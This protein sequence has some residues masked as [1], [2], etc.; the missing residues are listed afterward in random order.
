MLGDDQLL[1]N[2]KPRPGFGAANFWLAVFGEP[3]AEKPWAIQL[4]GHHIAVNITLVGEQIAMSPTFIGVQPHKFPFK[5]KEIVPMA[6][7]VEDAFAFVGALDDEQKNSAIVAEK[8]ADVQTAAGKDGFIPEAKGLKCDSLTEAQTNALLKLI[9]HWVNDL[10]AKQA[11]ARMKEIAG[12]IK[13]CHF[14]WSGPTAPGSDISFILQGPS[15]ILEYACQDLGGKPL[16]H[17]H[18]MYRDPTNE[19]GSRIVPE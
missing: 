9:A 17:L 13:D 16:D 14:A 2:G 5:G 10:P 1:P 8:R 4:D 18:S 15:L 3:S 11:E 7:E 12:Q 19:Y 6:Y